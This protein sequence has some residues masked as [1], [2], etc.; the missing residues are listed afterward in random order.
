MIE[1]MMVM[2]IIARKD[3]LQ[4]GFSHWTRASNSQSLAK[5]P[6]V[7][8]LAYCPHSERLLV[9]CS[10]LP[11]DNTFTVKMYVVIKHGGDDDYHQHCHRYHPHD[12]YIP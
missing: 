10:T 5:V 6:I 8:F 4:G 3:H 9:K 7:T 2:M 12:M 1:L 11:R